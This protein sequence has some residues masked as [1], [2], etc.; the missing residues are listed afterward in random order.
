MLLLQLSPVTGAWL[1]LTLSLELSQCTRHGMEYPC[2]LT[3]LHQQQSWRWSSS[4]SKKSLAWLLVLWWSLACHSP[5]PSWRFWVFLTEVTTLHFLLHRLKLSLWL[6]TLLSLKELYLLLALAL[7]RRLQAQT[8]LWFGL[9]SGTL[10]RSPRARLLLTA[11]S[12]L[13]VTQLQSG[14]LL[15]ILGLP[16]V[17]TAGAGD[18][19]PMHVTLKALSARNMMDYTE[20]KTTDLWLGAARLISSPT[21]LGRLLQLVLHALISSSV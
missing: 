9:I 11:L 1:R 12:I 15:C 10:R 21:L 5:S 20:W 13:D 16:S 17:A 8:C 6:L 14:G 7:W 3:L 18:I 2:L 19:Q 4:G